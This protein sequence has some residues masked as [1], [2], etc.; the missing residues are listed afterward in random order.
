VADV[1]HAFSRAWQTVGPPLPDAERLPRE[2]MAAAGKTRLRVIGDEPGTAGL[3]RLDQMVAG[4]AR[5]TLWLTDA[6]FA[7]P[8]SY[9]QALRAAALDGVDVRLLVPG[10]SDLALMQPVSR[11]G[12]RA[13]LDAG[14]RVFE[15]KGLMLHAKTAVCDGRWSRVGSTNLNIASWLSNYELDVVLDDAPF[16]EQMEDMFLEDLQNSTELIL[17][18]R[19]MRSRQPRP[20]P[21]R[22]PRR[23]RGS[24]G[25]AAAGALRVGNTVGAVL[26]ARRMVE[27]GEKR[28]VLLGGLVLL[29]LASLWA[30]FPHLL[31]VPVVVVLAWGGLALVWRA[32][33]LRTPQRPEGERV[34]PAPPSGESGAAQAGVERADVRG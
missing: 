29:A 8:P 14:I 34:L 13:L 6:Y 31:A 12:F 10:S 16:A 33:R 32:L 28:M 2:Q 7:A 18:G 4:A 30:V 9:V 19:R 27:G 17:A 25:R 15:W 5:Q 11:A 23:I 22:L 20:R 1:E 21:A 26:T 3:L 24:A